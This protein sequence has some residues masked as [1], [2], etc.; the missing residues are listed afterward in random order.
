MIA[1]PDPRPVVPAMTSKPYPV[2]P[3]GT[4]YFA[5]PLSEG[6]GVLFV[7]TQGNPAITATG[8]RAIAAM[9]SRP[10][11]TVD[12]FASPA[13]LA[14]WFSAAAQLVEEKAAAEAP[15]TVPEPVGVPSC[16]WPSTAPAP[17]FPPVDT[18]AMGVEVRRRSAEAREFLVAQFLVMSDDDAKKLGE[19]FGEWLMYR[20]TGGE[21]APLTELLDILTHPGAA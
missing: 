8:L 4:A 2:L 21:G 11:T 6:Q 20:R 17:H 10:G 5:N 7:N 12:V 16:G 3:P 13:T 14:T 15:E 18:A 9:L 19:L 1:G